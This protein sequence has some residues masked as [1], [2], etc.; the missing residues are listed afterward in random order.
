MVAKKTA[1]EPEKKTR[2]AFDLS[3]V[4]VGEA[5]PVPGAFARGGIPDDHP[6]A[7]LFT[8]S[9]EDGTALRVSTSTPDLVEKVLRKLATAR[10]LGVSIKRDSDASLVFQVG[11]RRTRPQKPRDVDEESYI[12][13]RDE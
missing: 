8:Q 2:Q 5:T 13:T 11:E 1:V 6:L 7:V 10:D 4:E 12:E 3:K 9:Y